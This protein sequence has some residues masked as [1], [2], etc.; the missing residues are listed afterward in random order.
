VG[1]GLESSPTLVQVPLL[2]LSTAAVELPT[3]SA[4][5]ARELLRLVSQAAAAVSAAAAA[6]L[7]LLLLPP[8]GARE[9]PAP[10]TDPSTR[11]GIPPAAAK[12][13][14][15]PF[16]PNLSRWLALLGL[17]SLAVAAASLAS[18]TWGCRAPGPPRACQR[19]DSA[20][21][22]CVEWGLLSLRGLSAGLALLMAQQHCP[23]RSSRSTPAAQR[24]AR[25]AAAGLSLALPALPLLVGVA[26]GAPLV[27]PAASCGAVP[28]ATLVARLGLN[29]LFLLLTVCSLGITR[30]APTRREGGTLHTSLTRA[31]VAPA[32]RLP[33]PTD[34]SCG[35]AAAGGERGRG[36]ASPLLA[37]CEDADGNHEGSACEPGGT[38]VCEEPLCDQLYRH[39]VRLSLL[40]C[41]AILATALS[42]SVQ[43]EELA[44]PPAAAGSGVGSGVQV[45]VLLMARLADAS[46][47]T[48]LFLLF[49]GRLA[50]APG[51]LRSL[52]RN[53]RAGELKA[54]PRQWG[55]IPRAESTLS[56]G[57]GESSG[58]DGAPAGDARADSA[59]EPASAEG[60]ASARRDSP[61]Q[62]GG[63]GLHP[64]VDLD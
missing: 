49:A 52:L 19:L 29:V 5:S 64:D 46:Y 48:V 24:R 60:L 47:G 40:L 62:G 8:R 17:G 2:I 27:H 44:S 20:L 45:E 7:L 21:S 39:R 58:S 4:E 6:A 28:R 38:A 9:T 42:L 31:A 11:G 54:F 12:P 10:S 26:F 34:A 15:V 50:R 25:L 36:A 1:A 35:A 61:A 18:A 30:L 3:S 63:A 51:L 55:A 53:L 22:A 37:G 13:R 32:A 56:L 57:A 14:P 59:V 43:V 16:G 23:E 41:F 33:R